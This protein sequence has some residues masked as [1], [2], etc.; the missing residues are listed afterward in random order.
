LQEQFR[1]QQHLSYV[2][3]VPE[4]DAAYQRARRWRAL[5]LLCLFAGGILEERASHRG[6]ESGDSMSCGTGRINRGVPPKTQ[7][8]R[9]E[10]AL[11]FL[12]DP[13]LRDTAT[14]QEYDECMEYL[15]IPKG[16]ER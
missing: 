14:P 2:S 12:N 15:K 4:T 11:R 7:Q 13:A 10:N 6:A 16:N 8:E 9:E 1:E 5:A 3:E